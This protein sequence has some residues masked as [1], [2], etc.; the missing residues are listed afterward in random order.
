M[1]VLCEQE[2]VGQDG[3]EAQPA[4]HVLCEASIQHA[5]TIYST[6][7]VVVSRYYQSCNTS[8]SMWDQP[9]HAVYYCT[10]LSSQEHYSRRTP[11]CVC[12]CV[13]YAA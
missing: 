2:H 4:P 7:R 1:P 9:T 5:C 13:L 6:K 3:Q 12:T 8:I 10:V 11:A